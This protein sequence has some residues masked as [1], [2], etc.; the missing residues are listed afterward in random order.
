MAV[1]ELVLDDVI[2]RLQSIATLGKRVE[3]VHDERE[4]MR[5]MVGA[6]L[7]VAGVIYEGML[8]NRDP[9]K[10]TH[11]T[12]LSQVDL[13]FAIIILYRLDELTG[14]SMQ[15]RSIG[16]MDEVR[17]S[18]KGKRSPTNHFYAF[19]QELGGELEKGLVVWMQRWS[20]V[21]QLT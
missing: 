2:A 21:T 17:D 10:S 5:R 14:V 7:P 13:N 19:R 16:F 11:K 6:S 8:S 12:G 3:L 18:I 4:L 1:V 15:R 20:T 9:E